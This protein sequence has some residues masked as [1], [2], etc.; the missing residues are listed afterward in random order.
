MI[1]A[2]ANP[3]DLATIGGMGQKGGWLYRIVTL[4]IIF[5]IPADASLLAYH[6]Y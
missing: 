2:D 6:L 5:F 4:L 3:L 1:I